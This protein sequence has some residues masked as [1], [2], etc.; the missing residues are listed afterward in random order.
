MAEAGREEKRLADYHQGV[1][2]ITVIVDAGWSKYSK[3]QLA[4]CLSL[5][6]NNSKEAKLGTKKGD[7]K[8]GVGI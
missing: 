3:L 8:G 1:P 2:T 5:T 6:W 7:A 4:K